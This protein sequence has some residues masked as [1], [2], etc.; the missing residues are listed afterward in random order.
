M[1]YDP[2]H[3]RR[4]TQARAKAKAVEAPDASVA[5]IAG[6]FVVFAALVLAAL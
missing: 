6:L 5:L 2:R 3:D 1:R 4:R